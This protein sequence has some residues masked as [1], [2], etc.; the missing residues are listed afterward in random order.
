MRARRR[1]GLFLRPRGGRG[2]MAHGLRGGLLRV[3]SRRGG[4]VGRVGC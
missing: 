2:S 4:G 3:P 1:G